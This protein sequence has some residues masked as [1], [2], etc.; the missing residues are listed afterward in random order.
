L[1]TAVPFSTNVALRSQPNGCAFARSVSEGVMDSVTGDGAVVDGA[2]VAEVAPARA[3]VVSVPAFGAAVGDGGDGWLRQPES[4][5]TSRIE[6]EIAVMRRFERTSASP[7]RGRKN[8]RYWLKN[9]IIAKRE[10]RGVRGVRGITEW[11]GPAALAEQYADASNLNARI[12]LHE[13]YS[14]N[15]TDRHRWIFD[16]FDPSPTRRRSRGS[17][18]NAWKTASCGS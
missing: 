10:G 4:A 2:S 6:R 17:S 12:A 7:R 1:A 15:Q 3:V 18:R 16:R 14:T 9:Y 8:R 13:R 5:V 11:T